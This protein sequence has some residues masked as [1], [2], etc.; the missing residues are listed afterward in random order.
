MNEQD[1]MFI[2]FNWKKWFELDAGSPIVARH[3]PFYITT[4]R[5]YDWYNWKPYLKSISEG[6]QLIGDFMSSIGDAGGSR[7]RSYL[8][9]L[10]YWMDNEKY[11]YMF[12]DDNNYLA[13]FIDV[14]KLDH[15][16]EIIDRT[17][18][19]MSSSNNNGLVRFMYIMLL[20]PNFLQ[21]SP[22]DVGGYLANNPMLCYGSGGFD[23]DLIFQHRNI[24]E[25]CKTD[26]AKKLFDF[27]TNNSWIRAHMAKEIGL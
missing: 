3:Y 19:Y 25:Y 12:A 5:D 6:A 7:Q 18:S 11:N 24:L 23:S 8:G 13:N 21:L 10:R 20:A 16:D 1:K 14:L 15:V 17:Q 26:A 27:I 2:P 9:A 4:E 22:E